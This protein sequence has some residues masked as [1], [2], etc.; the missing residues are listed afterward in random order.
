LE[1]SALITHPFKILLGISILV[2]FAAC[3]KTPGPD[4]N[5]STSGTNIPSGGSYDFNNVSP[6]TSKPA[7]F[8]ISNFGS[9]DLVLSGSPEKVKVTGAAFSVTTQPASPIAPG[10]SQT[11]TVTFSP[12]TNGSKTAAL[13]IASNDP[14]ESIYSITLN[15][16]GDRCS[17]HDAAVNLTPDS[18]ADDQNPAFSPD[19]KTLLFSS[20]RNGSGANLNLWKMDLLT[21]QA[22]PLTD[23]LNADNVNMPGSSWNSASNK[24][25]FASTQS[26]NEEIWTMAPDGTN[27][28]QITHTNNTVHDRAPT[29]SPD[30]KLVS[31][32]S[33]QYRGWEI[34]TIDVES[35]Q[36]GKLTNNTADDWKPNWSSTRDKIV[37]QSN[38]DGNWEIYTMNS[39]GTDV[40]NI[41]NDPADDTDPSWSPDGTKIVYASTHGGLDEPE[42]FVSNAG[43]IGEP[44]RI[45]DYAGH[46]GAPSFS[47]DGSSIAFESDR[48]GNLDIWLIPYTG[49]PSENPDWSTV[50]DFAYQLQNIDLAAIS[51]S[52][53]DLLIIDYS[54]DGSDAL[55]FTP[56]EIAALKNSAGGK[57]IVLAY[58]SI[59]EAQ[60]YRG[61]W[62]PAWV[63]GNPSWLDLQNPEQ[64]GNYAVQYWDPAW[65]AIIFGSPDSY[66][67]KIIAAGFDGV[68]LDHVNA[69]EYWGPG[70]SSGLNRAVAGQEMVDFVTSIAQYARVVKG[71]TSFGIFPQNAEALSS[72]ADYVQV[73]TGIGAEDVWYND[74][75]AQPSSYTSGV[76]QC[77][78]VFR[79][80]G[81][82]VLVVDYVT[83]ISKIDD[84][85]QK[86]VAKDY[87]PYAT[88][89]TLDVL[90][91]NS[92]HEPD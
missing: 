73:V 24:I 92:G 3:I 29:F 26:G 68:Y 46:D 13:T 64:P 79:S 80:A 30:G 72:H 7:T 83:Q 88:V 43:G 51:A 1:D 63:P 35:L 59:G 18:T 77:L 8:V 91:I 31:F 49:N 57:K 84:F 48:S 23:D 38:R 70:G 10:A 4:I 32:Q 22:D 17:Y 55:R 71:K 5:V 41:T 82:L 2:V 90:T 60:N 78:D 40:R 56:E 12:L 65:Q 87:V 53:F 42:I 19:G 89:R 14:D 20:K 54:A 37:F 75:S 67:N 33:D 28:Q 58:M 34:Y 39:D 50:N 85:Y 52:K 76:L 11:F 45:T 62:D 27:L 15:G 81:K 74:N 69:Y 44:E 21:S 61:Y 16:C 25:C 86:A 36:T 6:G 66:L 47:P 9:A